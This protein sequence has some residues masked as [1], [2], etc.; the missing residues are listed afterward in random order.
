[1]TIRKGQ[2][3][4]HHGALPSDGVIAESDAEVHR[5]INDARSTGRPIPTVGLI[6][7]DLARALG[8]TG[9]VA[10]LHSDQA[11]EVP[12]DIGVALVD[13][14]PR[15]FVAHLVVRHRMWSGRWVVAMNAEYLGGWKM[16][17][18]AHPNDGRLDVLEGQ[19][20]FD[21]RLKARRRLPSGDHLPHP[22]IR[23]RQVDA[24]QVEFDR[25]TPLWLDGVPY[26]R[27][28]AI[29]VRVEPDALRCVV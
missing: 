6:G 21:D 18:R 2:D 15:W 5:I 17:P 13:G 25:P 12:I 29:S 23:S 4:G 19:L 8:S 28:A 1:M 22:S 10:R 9:K 7:G 24:F 26:G 14:Q 27:V 16:A 11:R 20:S 3:W